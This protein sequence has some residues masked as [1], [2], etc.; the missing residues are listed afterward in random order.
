MALRISAVCLLALILQL[1][2]FAHMRIVGVAP[3]LLAMVSAMAGLMAGSQRGS[4]IAFCAG[5]IW[6]VHL[7]TPL[8]LSAVSFSLMAYA[9]GSI[10]DGLFYGTRIQMMALVLVGTA[11]TVMIY[12][13]L[14][15]LIGQ[16]SLVN[17][18]L[19][20]VAVLASLMNAVL[21]IAAAPLMRWAVR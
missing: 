16:D 7:S 18:G 17:T 1:T 20:R 15:E 4:L 11:A 9:V 3:E 5:L 14:G 12:A 2:V 10:G 13:F 21:S 6:D 8:G 19:L